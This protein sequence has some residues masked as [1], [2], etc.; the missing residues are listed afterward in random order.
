[1][2]QK[3]PTNALHCMHVILLNSNH[4]HVSAGHLQGGENKNTIITDVS[5]L[6]KRRVN[7][8]RL[9]EILFLFWPHEFTEYVAGYYIMKLDPYSRVHLL[10]LFK[11]LYK[12]SVFGDHNFSSVIVFP[13]PSVIIRLSHNTCCL[14]QCRQPCG[15]RRICP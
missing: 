9:I 14:L 5:E 15:H 3:E 1:M 13:L 12:V 8:D 2:Y 7:T 11:K 4:R 10:A 6:S